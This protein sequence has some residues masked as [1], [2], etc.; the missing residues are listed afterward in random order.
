VTAA[1]AGSGETTITIP[2]G[3]VSD[4]GGLTG[5]AD[6]DHTQYFNNARL[7]T[8]LDGY[9]TDAELS[10][11]TGDAT[12]H[13]TESSIDHG[14]IAGLTDDDHTQYFNNIRLE[15]V[16]DG[17]ITDADFSSHTGD[18]T[19]HFTEASIDHG[20]ITGLGDD[21]HT[22][23][24]NDIRLESVLDGYTTDAEFSAHTG[25]ATIH[26]TESSID[27]GS[28]TGLGDD[29]H[30]QYF[31]S[32]RLES[33]LDGYTT[34]AEFSGHTGDTTI[35]F[36]EASIDHGSIT[37]L[38]DD[39]HAQYFNSIRLEAVLD[40]YTTDTEFSAHTGDATIHFTEASIDHGSVTGLGDDDHTQYFN[41]FRLEAILDGYTTDA[42][43]SSHTGDGTIHFTESSID[44][45]SIAGLTDDDHTQYFNITR[46]DVVVDGY[47]DGTGADN[48]V[49]IWSGTSSL[50][51]SSS[52]TFDGS[53]LSVT[54]DVIPGTDNIYDLG[55]PTLRWQD[56]YFGPGTIHIGTSV[57]DE[58][59]LS[60]NTTN[61]EFAISSD[62]Y[63]TF[64]DLTKGVSSYSTAFRLSDTASEWNT[65]EGNFGEVSL[66]NAINQ[67]SAGGGGDVTKVGTPVDN[68]I[69]V[70]T[71][72]GTIEGD[73]G[74]TWTGSAFAADG[75]AVFNETGTAVD[76]RV[77]SNNL[78]H[79]LFVDGDTDRVGIGTDTPIARF[80]VVDEG[81]SP[82]LFNIANFNDTSDS[83]EL[84]FRKARGT[85]ASPTIVLED[86]SAPSFFFQGYD[87]SVFR[88]LAAIVSSVDG[89]P[90][91]DDMPGSLSFW[92]NPDGTSQTVTERMRIDN[93]GSVG[94]GTTSPTAL[95][96]VADEGSSP[97]LFH[98]ANFNDTSD[99]GELRFR[100]ARGTEASPTTVSSGDLPP[101]F[102]F[103]A[104]DGS[105][106]RNLAMIATA[107]DGAPG[108]NDMPGRI[109]F[110]TSPDGTSSLTERM[111]IDN[112]G[113]VR[114]LQDS[115]SLSV[116]AGD[117]LALSHN[118]TNSTITS[119]TGDLIIDNT[120]ATGSTINRLGTDT[121]VTD[122]QV[123]NNSETAL[124]TIDGYGTSVFTGELLAKRSVSLIVDTTSPSEITDNRII[125]TNQ[126]S[127]SQVTVNLPTA[128]IGLEYEFIVQDANG[129]T[130]TAASGDTIRQA[131]SVSTAGGTASSTTVGDTIRLVAINSSEWITIASQGTWSLA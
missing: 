84:R 68:Q 7:E 61:D 71:G 105:T 80:S 107:V 114:V 65:F 92:T 112:A 93:A 55:S 3:G 14:S 127:L 67:V 120:L 51:S 39:D 21:D 16:L 91:S 42:E 95:L 119:A 97:E 82:E 56:G 62:G 131:G 1:D 47:V 45:G 46:L 32:I 110:Y 106:F 35:H 78:T 74:L 8:V 59:T 122:F 30:P 121:S 113:N 11:H 117:D 126:G 41:S 85:E 89:T 90:G 10:G 37:G 25:N 9:T 96:T 83:G 100:K 18:A 88:N 75:S 17:Y 4:H 33:L 116:G 86:D 94:I 111:R 76:F 81:S 24:F 52:L 129:F 57:V 26:F 98:I 123:Q 109:E 108:S 115:V 22:Q 130:I 2:G 87:G 103:Q 34:D 43:F 72:D 36:T 63:I 128:S 48:Q 73:T 12:I 125:Y 77:E 102:V 28:I 19:I 20:S 101:V 29:D 15:A 54:G 60:Y 118:G 40:G 104:H 66:L 58:A 38:G 6:D 124:L 53:I 31:N 27:H 79:A 13:F 70:W 5:L 69:G 49:A 23:Y 44:H 99:S 50:D 64:N